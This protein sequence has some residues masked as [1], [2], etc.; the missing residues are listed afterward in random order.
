MKANIFLA[1]LLSLPGLAAA[2]EGCPKGYRPIGSCD[3]ISDA[4]SRVVIRQDAPRS[5]LEAEARRLGHRVLVG[6]GDGH[7]E[8]GPSD[9]DAA[10]SP[11]EAGTGANERTEHQQRRARFRDAHP[12]PVTRIQAREPAQCPPGYSSAHSRCFCRLPDNA[13]VNS[14]PE[15]KAYEAAR[16][17]SGRTGLR[18][19]EEFDPAW[20]AIKQ[21]PATNAPSNCDAD[22][23]NYAQRLADERKRFYCEHMRPV[24][25]PALISAKLKAHHE[26]K[27]REFEALCGQ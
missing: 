21:V 1:F 11:G 23:T 20:W 15:L 3:C 4:D 17:S 27:K 26:E 10:P 24:N 2:D 9:P 6:N 14:S 5:C 7:F 13:S 22:L 8:L 16:A 19:R 25:A 18:Y 12:F